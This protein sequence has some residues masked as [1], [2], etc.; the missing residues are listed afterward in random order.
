M[1]KVARPP[2]DHVEMPKRLFDCLPLLGR[3]GLQMTT[4]TGPLRPAQ[5]QYAVNFLDMGDPPRFR[6]EAV[7]MLRSADAA[8]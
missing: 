7:V 3:A 4:P 1:G 6:D 8:C 5:R 2:S